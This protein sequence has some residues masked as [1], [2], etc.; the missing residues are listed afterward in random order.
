MS[1]WDG[2][3]MRIW[4]IFHLF[5]TPKYPHHHNLTHPIPCYEPASTKHYNQALV[6]KNPNKIKRNYTSRNKCRRATNFFLNFFIRCRAVLSHHH[7][8]TTIVHVLSQHTVIFVHICNWEHLPSL[9]T[10]GEPLAGSAEQ[11]QRIVCRVADVVNDRLMSLEKV[12][13]M[14]WR[15]GWQSHDNNSRQQCGN[16]AGW[17]IKKYYDVTFDVLRRG[18]NH[19]YL[20][21][22]RLKVTCNRLGCVMQHFRS[23]GVDENMVRSDSRR[24]IHRVVG[25]YNE[26]ITL[27]KRIWRVSVLKTDLQQ[28]E[29][30]RNRYVWEPEATF[31][32]YALALLLSTVFFATPQFTMPHKGCEVRMR[33]A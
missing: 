1:K 16:D 9:K 31:S 8:F 32:T 33:K 12:M 19:T 23:P 18:E 14:W 28:N 29:L 17:V 11:R 2:N 13:S 20:L 5:L 4:S 15:Y 3:K 10:F 21:S 27:K 25:M 7:H 22:V 6:A 24:H 30:S 26:L